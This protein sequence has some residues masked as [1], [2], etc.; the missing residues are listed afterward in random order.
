MK[1]I[2]AKKNIH[3]PLL[4][5]LSTGKSFSFA[6]LLT[7]QKQFYK[8]FELSRDLSEVC[9]IV[10]SSQSIWQKSQSTL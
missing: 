7:E 2:Q 9:R 8:F 3:M 10:K 1:H 6:S 4:H 5:C